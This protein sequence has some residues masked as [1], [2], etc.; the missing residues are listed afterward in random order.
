MHLTLDLSQ[1][2]DTLNRVE[3]TLLQLSTKQEKLVNIHEQFAKRLEGIEG[4]VSYLVN[5]QDELQKQQVS[6]ENRLAS[7]E[8]LAEL[9]TIMSDIT[10]L[11]SHLQLKQDQLASKQ[12]LLH[13]TIA[14]EPASASVISSPI[15]SPPLPAQITWNPCPPRFTPP[16]PT[17]PTVPRW[18]SQSCTPVL[19][20]L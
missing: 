5:K 10:K 2:L 14:N 13:S 19:F 18:R 9:H 16:V 20:P 17:T 7:K 11:Q 3:S 4:R 15:L 12:D 1:K 8:Q 6:I